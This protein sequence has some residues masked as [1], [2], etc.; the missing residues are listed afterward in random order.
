MPDSIQLRLHHETINDA[1]TEVVQA[2][3]GPKKVGA[4]MR[5]DKPVEESSRWVRDCLNAERR[6]HFDPEQIIFL[7]AKAREIHCHGAMAF[8]SNAT[9]YSATPI[10]PADEAAKLQREFIECAR[11]QGKMLERLAQL[12]AVNLKAVA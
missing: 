10:E 1:L 9:G 6:E 11:L 8:L 2:L 12:G 3:G 4:M 5:P 7:L